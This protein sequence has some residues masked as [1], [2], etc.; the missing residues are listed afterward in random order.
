[1]SVSAVFSDEEYRHDHRRD[2][3][4]LVQADKAESDETLGSSDRLWSRQSRVDQRHT[5]TQPD[6][7]LP[8]PH[9]PVRAVHRTTTL[10]N[11]P[12]KLSK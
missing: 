2:D 1:M 4:E 6:P 11:S 7:I 12:S 3:D 10:L 8:L 9:T 5:D